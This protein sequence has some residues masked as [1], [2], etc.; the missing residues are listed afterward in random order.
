MPQ[1]QYNAI[2]AA[3]NRKSGTVE[4]G[5]LEAARA[6][7]QA[8]ALSAVELKLET[9]AGKPVALSA[10]ESLELTTQIAELA[11]AGLPLAAGLRAM[12]ADLPSG[13]LSK[14]V[15]LLAGWLEAGVPVD[16]ALAQAAAWL[17][18]HIRGMLAAG[19]HSGRL[20]EVLQESLA[21]EQLQ[22]ESRRRMSAVMAYPLI[23]FT[24]FLGWLAFVLCLLMP[25]MSQVYDDFGVYLPTST[26]ILVFLSGPGKW[27]LLVPLAAIDVAPWVLRSF[28]HTYVA[29]WLLARLPLIG[30]AWRSRSLVGFCNLLAGLLEQSIPLPAALR[31]TADGV[32]D[33][34]LKAACNNA[35]IE[36]AG[37]RSLSQCLGRVQTFP[38]T[39]VPIVRWGEQTSEVGKS[40]RSA[41]DLYLNRL[42]L[43]TQLLSMVIPPVVFVFIASATL[44]IVMATF[45]P[46]IRLVTALSG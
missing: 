19:V 43:Q 12:Q 45:A 24:V 26:R 42:A 40:L 1:F 16:Q 39:L 27:L 32:R 11:K 37:G 29:S 10:A 2:D 28:S 7:L 3:G 46:M 35:A 41:A 30:P 22:A 20:P 34:E 23:V 31:L 13:R 15:H 8:A 5:D 38:H 33:G 9:P 44:W 18:G 6:Q 25:S 14:A 4:A 36:A 21:Y 17:P